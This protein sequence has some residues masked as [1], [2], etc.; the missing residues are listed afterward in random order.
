MLPP[1]HAGGKISDIV[2]EGDYDL[3]TVLANTEKDGQKIPILKCITN[4]L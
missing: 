1:D 2:S 4:G 3:E